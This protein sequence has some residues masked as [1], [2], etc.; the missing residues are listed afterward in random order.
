MET[1]GLLKI[2]TSL[3]DKTAQSPLLP[4]STPPSSDDAPHANADEKEKNDFPFP[5][6][7]RENAFVK[8][9]ERHQTQSKRIDEREKKR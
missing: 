6:Q 3:L 7:E 8:L 4:S 1:F 9:M 2:L 5:S